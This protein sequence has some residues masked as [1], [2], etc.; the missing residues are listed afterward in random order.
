MVYTTKVYGMEWFKNDSE[1]GAQLQCLN[2]MKETEIIIKSDTQK[3]GQMWG[4]TTEKVLLK[5]LETNKGIYEIISHFPH[6]VYFDI[7]CHQETEKMLTSEEQETHLN[8][9]LIH[10]EEFFP[11]ADIAVSGS[12]TSTK[13]SYHIVLNNYIIQNEE[14]RQTIKTLV[15]YICNNCDKDYDWKVYTKNRCM[16]AI[17]QSKRDG[18]VQEIIKNEDWKKHLIT[19]FISQ[20]GILPFPELNSLSPEVKEEI[21]IEKSKGSF[22]L[23]ELPKMVLKTPDNFDVNTASPLE[24]LSMLPIGA[25][26]N[27]TYTHLVARFCGSNGLTLEHFWSWIEKKH[28]ET[29]KD[30]KTEYAKWSH[31]FKNLNKYPAVSEERIKNVLYYYYPHLKKD[32]TFRDFQ[33]TFILPTEKIEK[34]ET[35][36]P[37]TFQVPE[38]YLIYNVGMGGGKTAQ[39]ISYLSKCDDFLWIAPNKALA[40]NT[41]KRFEDE[42]VEV[43]HY[44]EYKTKDKKQGDLNEVKKLII[45]LNSLHY[46]KEKN[47]EVL[48]IDE[49]ETLLDKFL[50]D[51]MEQGKLQLKKPIWEIFKKIICNAKKVI[52]LDAFITSKTINFINNIEKNATIKIYERIKEPQTRTIKYRDDF[53]AVLYSIIQKIKD[54]SKLFIFYPYKKDSGS[55]RGMEA[56]YKTICSATGKKGIFYN[57]DVDDKKK[58]G[59]KDVNNSWKDK[60]FIITNNIITCGVNYENE[61]FD[62]KYLFI[63][64]F[65]TPR[66]IIQVS[67]RARHL[68]TGII[69]I[70]YMG[71]MNQNNT[72]E[73]DC[74]KIGC[75]IYKK[76]YVDILIEKKAPLKRSFQ[77]FCI[78]AHYNQEVEKLQIDAA[79]TNEIKKTLSDQQIGFKYSKIQ[80]L[81]ISEADFIEQKCLGQDATLYD[82]LCLKK[83]YYQKK[84]LDR[85]A[86]ELDEIWEN[87]LLFFFD[88]LESVFLNEDSVFKKI[89]NLNNLE[90]IFPIDIKK[91]KLD[92]KIKT[93]IFTEFSFKF[94]TEKSG[95]AKII[96]E[97][98][99][100]FFGKHLIITDQDANKHATYKYNA[101]L[102]DITKIYNFGL[103]N[104]IINQEI[105]LTYLDYLQSDEDLIEI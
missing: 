94:I 100:T 21:M 97:I 17:G 92:D 37:A 22:D 33:Q 80:D 29:K 38:K 69:N 44:L 50:G 95:S 36:T 70:C 9:T 23:S 81:D 39:S 74:Q 7:D 89:Q 15:R 75:D 27:H 5:L 46:I 86:E 25:N 93:Q 34:I 57:A 96:K 32:K 64:P 83:Y 13:I 91:T 20:V 10:I 1:G 88:K 28:K 12:Y 104:R 66:D 48:I 35:I 87:D 99:N 59:L 24:L 8:N 30:L 61:D 41:K 47:Y 26:F 71:K 102:P 45:V 82:K 4:S 65:N 51:F 55:I 40:T 54:G 63:A 101:N 77:L 43:G 6:K 2:Q 14:E 31:H 76:L 79:I 90:T 67:Y 72:W 18:R 68:S 58:V 16:K 78:K 85:N 42:D 52:F 49:I 84:F 62:Y 98:Y 60:S 56:V 73:N 3:N 19:C 103:K 105:N 53:E 11:Q